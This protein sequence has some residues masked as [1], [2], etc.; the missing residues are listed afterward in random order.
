MPEP[1]PTDFTVTP[2]STYNRISWTN[3]E[4]DPAS[5]VGIG[6]KS[7]I[8]STFYG[9]A[10]IVY[11]GY[12]YDDYDIT[13]YDNI[14]LQYYA[15]CYLPPFDPSPATSTVTV[16]RWGDT[17]TDTVTGSDTATGTQTF[18]DTVS[19]TVTGATSASV[20]IT[21]ASTAS[22]T[23]TASDGTTDAQIIKTAFAYYIGM[24]DG[25]VHAISPDTLSDNGTSI[26]SIWETIET[27][28]G[29]PSV[30][31]TVYTSALRYV[32][33][34]ATTPVS[35]SIS[36]DGG[37]TWSGSAKSVGTGDGKTHTK[38]FFWTGISGEYFKF[39]VELASTNKEFQ[40]IGL[41]VDFLVD[42]D[43]LDE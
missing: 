28:L 5:Y 16:T 29:I 35:V 1:T 38:K 20:L 25:T 36:N 39:K 2:Y 6:R 11:P 17:S 4:T 26:T 42:G 12:Y 14:G 27:N 32:D 21:W 41:D 13:G 15:I 30:Y 10:N 24:Y 23:V 31:K 40:I 19:D 7:T 8:E 37:A 3:V 33:K 43:T 18:V 9:L 34:T 22:D